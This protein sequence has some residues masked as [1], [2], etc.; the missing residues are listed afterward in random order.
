MLNNNLW[1]LQL[2]AEGG[3]GSASGAEG[4]AVADTG[5]TDEAAAHHQRL[6]ELGVPENK[7][8]KNRSY[9]PST[10]S[11]ATAE[12][13]PVA[14][15]TEE[16][17]QVTAA[18][19]EP[20]DEKPK[21]MTWDEIKADPEYSEQLNK[22]M[23]DRL[24]KS[25]G[26]EEAME[27]L[28]PA[29]DALVKVYGLDPEKVDYAS[30]AEKIQ[31]DDRL[32][33][34][35]ALEMGVDASIARKVDQFDL[36][37]SRQRE[38][39]EKTIQER[40]FNE[41]LT[42]LSEQG[43]ALKAKFPGFD[44]KK[45]ME[46]PVFRRMTAPGEGIMSVEDAYRFVHHKEFEQAALKAASDQAAKN[47]ANAVRSGTMR[48]KENGTSAAA[49]SVSTFNYRTASKEQRDALKARIRQAGARGEK[50]YPGQ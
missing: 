25:K 2:F 5:V 14:T 21:R 46:N 15:Q 44:L 26:A 38:Q 9:K 16:A 23:R 36:M 8:R 20:T 28:T 39:Q 19:S 35:K 49:P 1:L 32:Y 3:E 50:I 33:E 13:E 12:A 7:I 31:G 24:K 29:L 6:R 4:A 30:L 17:G 11:K 47:M 42:K 41:H 10:P 22:M 40:M 34:D 37:A 48:P 18:E 45:E 27:A 43:D